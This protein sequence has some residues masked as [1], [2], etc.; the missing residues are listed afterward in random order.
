MNKKLNLSILSML[1]LSII[2]IM[3]FITSINLIY[4]DL[5]VFIEIELISLNSSSIEM[6]LM[7][8]WISMFFF[9]CVMM[10]S[11]MV[12]FYS[13]SY[14]S[15]EVYME[16]FIL[17]I[18]LFVLSMVL[19]IFSLNLI[20]ILLG[21]DGLGLV[22]FCLVIY[23][24]NSKSLNSG[25]LT[26]LSNRVGD[27]LILLSISYFI[28]F[29][30]WNF[31]P[32]VKIS[33]LNGE[34]MSLILV[35]MVL[36][37]MTKSAQIPFAAWL[38][39]AMAAPTP[40]SA[41][42]HSSTLVTA[43]VYLLVRMIEFESLSLILN[44]LLIISSLTMLMAGI[45]ANFEFD[46]KKIIALSTLSQLGLM[47]AILCLGFKN[48]AFFHLCSHA[49]FKSL[50]FMCAG[51]IIHNMKNWQDIRMMGGIGYF[52]P[53]VFINLN[54][55]NLALCGMPFLAGFYSKDLILEMVMFSNFNLM[56][57]FFFFFSVG[58]TVSYSVRLIYL[59]FLKE[60]NLSSYYSLDDKDSIMLGSMFFLLMMSIMG[61]SLMMWL[62][63]PKLYFIFISFYLKSMVM[64][65]MGI[66]FMVGVLV[67]KFNLVL[68]NK[69]SL[70]ILFF[71]SLMWFIPNI[72]LFSFNKLLLKLSLNIDK[73]LDLG[74]LEELGGMKLYK[75]MISVGAS[76][77]YLHL[78]YLKIFIYLF[79]FFFFFF[80]MI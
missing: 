23:Y 48:L 12:I 36:A 27:V 54:I 44:F 14:M 79:G 40:I 28:N 35:L 51:M 30:S 52:M 20:S 77:Y 3:S 19:L 32:Y 34:M 46:L 80:L 17:L 78:S 4:L 75:F 61:G 26:I 76:N 60:W 62:I 68:N 16:R 63:L 41:L 58:M 24:Q 25:V 29:G 22:S 37:S 33:F 10:I 42:V 38:P 18:I 73:V 21:W 57:F 64:I 2:G 9:F 1:F 15:G 67:A 31:L 43:G 53:M 8:D 50:L 65:T 45:S 66:G 71:F 5:S 13:K 69:Y 55:A 56:I 11:S 7:I 47:M 72:T 74:W 59:N 70:K 39:A 6:V 49:M